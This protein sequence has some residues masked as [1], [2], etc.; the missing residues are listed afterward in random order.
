MRPL[1]ALLLLLP[2][3]MPT[4]AQA[5]TR[6]TGDLVP[7]AQWQTTRPESVGYSSRKLEA[8]RAWVKAQDTSSMM[9][10][11]QGRVLFSEG[12]VAHVSKIASIRKSILG[13]LCGPYV[14]GKIDPGLTVV[15]LGLQEK[16]PFL[17]IEAHANL[18]QLLAGRSGFYPA[19]EDHLPRRG[20]HYPGT[21]FAYQNWDFNAAGDAFE[22]LTGKGIYDAL[23]T[24]LAAPLGMQDFVLNRQH[25]NPEP[26]S[27]HPEYAM[28]LS[29]R[30]LARLGLLMLNVGSWNAKQIIPADWVRYM[31]SLVTPFSDVHPTEF[32]N[33][34]E[35]ERWG[36][37]YT[38]WVWDQPAYP[39]DIYTGFLQGAYS[40]MGTGGQFL[41]VLPAR[42]MVVVH[43]VDID[44]DEHAAVSPSSYIAMLAMLENS[45]CGETCP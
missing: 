36:F 42:D 31:T 15:Q 3:A 34:G 35:P 26:G 45:R 44:K 13:M 28:Y 7:G 39:G 17:P 9:V 38:W 37:G 30:D 32:S 8:L 1:L 25:K 2:A 12:D 41:T 11:V 5:P 14:G 19:T 18:N 23:E 10:V 22:K 4:H 40:A 29:A 43:R 24:D 20:S 21:Y 27:V 16:E 33:A 6:I